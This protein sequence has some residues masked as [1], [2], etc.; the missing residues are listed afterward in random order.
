MTK[1]V[2]FVLVLIAVLA[3]FLVL[4]GDDARLVITSSADSGLL[5]INGIDM[6]WQSAIFVF[7]LFIMGLLAFWSFITWIWRLPDRL[8]AG[9]GLRRYNQALDAMEETLL[10]AADGDVVRSR[11]RAK[12]MR[13]LVKSESLG[14]VISAQAAVISGDQAEA[15]N[16]YRAMLDDEKTLLTARRGLAQQCLMSGD[17]AGVMEHAGTTYQDNKNAAWEFD[18]LFQAQVSDGRWSEA[19]ETLDLGLKRKH[20][21]RDVG[22]RRRAVLETAEAAR[23]VGT[24]DLPAAADMA[25][26]AAQ[27]APEFTPAVALAA[28][29]HVRQGEIRKAV[30][31]IEKAWSVRPHPALGIAYRSAIEGLSE[32]DRARRMNQLLKTNPDHRETRILEIENALHAGDAV[33]A[34]SELSPLLQNTEPT[35]RLCLLAAAAETMLENPVD[36]AVWTRRA[37]TAAS[38]PDWADI[39]PDGGAFDYE[40]KDWRRLVFSY[41]ETGDLIHPR[42]ETGAALKPVLDEKTN[43]GS[44][45]SGEDKTDNPPEA[46]DGATGG[47]I[48]GPSGPAP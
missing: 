20:V 47:R 48:I 23:L 19:L 1:Y 16:Q 38:E 36:A 11:R 29:L 2:I 31:V 30:S 6:S 35:T 13:E 33:A 40:D 37:A 17:L 46:T 3:V 43:T 21:D 22:Q 5:A 39:A 24:G 44:V 15:V 27:A 41:G 8:R 14:R 32:K 9:L 12:K 7:T 42:F 26:R 34:W 10:A 18:A 25:D 4:I 28:N 45:R